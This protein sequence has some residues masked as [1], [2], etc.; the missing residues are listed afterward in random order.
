MTKEKYFRL[1]DFIEDMQETYP[2]RSCFQIL[3]MIPPE[4]MNEKEYD[5]M[6]EDMENNDVFVDGRYII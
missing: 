5:F 1:R 4:E 6:Y 3:D 2:S